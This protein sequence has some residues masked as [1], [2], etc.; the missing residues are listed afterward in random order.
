MIDSQ[1]LKHIY[2]YFVSPLVN[3]L[4]QRSSH[5]NQIVLISELALSNTM[6][7]PW[8]RGDTPLTWHSWVPVAPETSFFAPHSLPVLS[9]VHFP[10]VLRGLVARSI[11]CYLVLIYSLETLRLHCGFPLSLIS[12]D[13]SAQLTLPS[14][15]THWVISFTI[16]LAQYAYHPK[17]YKPNWNVYKRTIE[18]PVTSTLTFYGESLNWGCG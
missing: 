4:A 7:M 8:R 11:S 18:I 2:T 1:G 5:R 15:H 10:H 12:C 3:G 13:L 9:R 16:D 14:A 17:Y 6:S